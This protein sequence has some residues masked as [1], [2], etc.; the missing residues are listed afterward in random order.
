[1]KPSTQAHQRH[2]SA[3]RVPVT[4]RFE[5]AS[6]HEHDDEARGLTD[7]DAAARPPRPTTA[8]QRK[9][10]ASHS[11]SIEWLREPLLLRESGPARVLGY[12]RD[13]ERPTWLM[14]AA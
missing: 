7:R 1:M 2:K 10:R 3:R 11:G 8:A 13:I 5:R 4:Q 12:D 6:E 14:D 9:V